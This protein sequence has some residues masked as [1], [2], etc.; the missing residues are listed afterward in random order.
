MVKRRMRVGK[1]YTVGL[2][3]WRETRQGK[4]KTGKRGGR[5]RRRKKMDWERIFE[6]VFKRGIKEAREGSDERGIDRGR[7]DERGRGQKRIR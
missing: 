4:Q 7:M 3:Q 5:K 6:M 2:E 1:R